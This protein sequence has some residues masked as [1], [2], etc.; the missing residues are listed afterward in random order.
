MGSTPSSYTIGIYVLYTKNLMGSIMRVYTCP[1]C[2]A[3]FSRHE[4]YSDCEIAVCIGCKPRV[5]K[6]KAVKAKKKRR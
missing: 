5:D 1:K 6:A 4:S 3:T 2:G